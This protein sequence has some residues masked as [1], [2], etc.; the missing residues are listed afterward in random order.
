VKAESL[1]ST[2]QENQ[3]LKCPEAAALLLITPKTIRSMARENRIPAHRDE[4][5]RDWLFQEDELLKWFF[6]LPL[7]TA[8][9]EI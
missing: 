2:L 9:N 1:S 4:G 6:A 7:H 5:R 8:E 3:W